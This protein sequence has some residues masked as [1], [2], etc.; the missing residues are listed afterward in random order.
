M[1]Y[2]VNVLQRYLTFTSSHLH[3]VEEFPG[4][5][6]SVSNVLLSRMG[7]KSGGGNQK[8]AIE[9]ASSLRGAVRRRSSLVNVLKD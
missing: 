2:T 7:I 6:I 9:E 4:E 5:V 1:S 3:I 8:D